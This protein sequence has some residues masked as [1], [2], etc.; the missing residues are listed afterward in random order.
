GDGNGLIDAGD[1]GSLLIQ[2]RNTG[3]ANATAIS[4]TLTSP[5]A[6]V[7]ITQPNTSAYPD[8]AA[9]GGTGTNLSPLRFTV[10]GN[11][12]CPAVLH[13]T[14]TVNYT[15]GRSPQV[16]T[17]TIPVGPPPVNISSA[18]DTTAP[19]SGPGFVGT[20]GTIGTREFRDGI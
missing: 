15:G 1:G 5:D 18:L 6:G 7:I 11:V 14:L 9:Q 17:F 13:F 2:L 12:T 8:L 16:M 4:T 3:V 10:A 20:T 19:A